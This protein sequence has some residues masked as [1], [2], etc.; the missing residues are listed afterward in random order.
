MLR[1]TRADE[2]PCESSSREE[3]RAEN[4]RVAGRKALNNE[5]IR[6]EFMGLLVSE[7]SNQSSTC[8]GSSGSCNLSK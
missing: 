6:D 3:N 4:G 1:Q 8:E 7:L 5:A 2:V